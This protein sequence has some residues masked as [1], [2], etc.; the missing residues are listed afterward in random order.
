MRK[1]EHEL[2]REFPVIE[3]TVT[4]SN[5]YR[6]RLPNGRSVFC[7]ATPSDRRSMKIIRAEIRRQA[8]HRG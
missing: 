3:I 7:S 6:L 8:R 1:L 4:G 2:K 5:H